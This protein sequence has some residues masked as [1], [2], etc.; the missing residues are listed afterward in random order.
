MADIIKVKNATELN[1]LLNENENVVV[2]F[3]AEWCGPCRIMNDI[4]KNFTDESAN[5]VVFIEIDVDEVEFSDIIETYGVRNL[6]TFLF[7]KK[8][9]VKDKKVGTIQN[10]ELSFWLNKNK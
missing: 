5:N 4:I 6:P 1:K 3:S 7:F 2:K 8:R 9:E 10:N